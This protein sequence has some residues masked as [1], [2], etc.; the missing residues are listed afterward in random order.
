MFRKICVD[1]AKIRTGLGNKC[2]LRI[3]IGFWKRSL[4]NFGFVE[5]THTR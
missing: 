4:G 5:H 1:V 3:K 2:L